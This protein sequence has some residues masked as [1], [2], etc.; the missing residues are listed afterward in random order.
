[1]TVRVRIAPSPTGHLH[2]G[3]AR[4]ALF[5][6]LFARHNDGIFIVRIDDTDRERSTTEFETD[7]LDSLRWLGLQ[8]DEGVE[9]GGPHGTYRQS[10]RYD[11][12][13]EAAAGLVASGAAYYD[14][15]TPDELEEL[16]YRAQGEGKHPG[17]YIRRPE[18]AA[19]ERGDP[20]LDPSGCARGLRGPG[21][22]KGE[23][24][25]T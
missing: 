1:M 4:A 2:V 23:F 20:G 25:A 10:D 13:R 22:W 11:R 9:V 24:R 18:S 19:G 5:N 12:Y 6:W 21:A 3:T 17:H 16:R 7:I 8:W 15:R 14:N